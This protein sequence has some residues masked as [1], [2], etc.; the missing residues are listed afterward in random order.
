MREAKPRWNHALPAS[1]PTRLSPSSGWGLLLSRNVAQLLD[2]P[3]ITPRRKP[4]VAARSEPRAR[5]LVGHGIRPA[6]GRSEPPALGVTG[7]SSAGGFGS[8]RVAIG[9]HLPTV[10]PTSETPL[11]RLDARW[12]EA[13]VRSVRE[14]ALWS[15]FR[16]FNLLMATSR[17]TNCV[18]HAGARE[19]NGED[20][21]NECIPGQRM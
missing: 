14:V 11:K 7:A 21:R 9:K 1:C 20:P 15:R 2:R 18:G 19:T 8:E 5:G 10:T 12:I 16:T 17:L 13:Y 3:P 4:W 6:V